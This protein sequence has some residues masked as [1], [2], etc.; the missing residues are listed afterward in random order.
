MREDDFVEYF[1]FP[2]LE[3]AGNSASESVLKNFLDQVNKVVAKYAGKYLWHRDAFRVCVR[4]SDHVLLSEEEHPGKLCWI[5][6]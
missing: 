6:N 5:L 3:N 4:N 1:I 2:S